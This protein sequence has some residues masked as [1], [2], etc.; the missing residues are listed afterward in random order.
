MDIITPRDALF[1]LPAGTRRVNYAEHQPEYL[2]L[3]SLVT[4]DGKV[5]SQW[6]PDANDLALLN[7]GVAVTLVL[8]T[9]NQ[10]LQPIFLAVGG[11]DLR[12]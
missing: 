1:L 12:S 2:T 7:N 10:P 11:L 8:Y 9:F 3:P 5:V 4:P 6:L